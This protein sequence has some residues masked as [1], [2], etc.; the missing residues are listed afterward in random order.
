MVA[1]SGSCSADSSC[2]RTWPD[3]VREQLLLNGASWRNTQSSPC[4]AAIGIGIQASLRE[5]VA[6]SQKQLGLMPNTFMRTSAGTAGADTDAPP[7][8]GVDG[9]TSLALF[10][11]GGYKKKRPSLCLVNSSIVRSGSA[12]PL[13]QQSQPMSYKLR[14]RHRSRLLLEPAMIQTNAVARHGDDCVFRHEC[15]LTKTAP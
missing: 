2:P 13:G 15:S 11:G 3:F 7:T 1:K 8:A 14:I 5:I 4:R 10:G 12:L 9:N 6:G